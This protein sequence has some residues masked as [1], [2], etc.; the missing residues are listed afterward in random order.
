[1]NHDTPTPKRT[2]KSR[3]LYKSKNAT[4]WPGVTRY[5]GDYAAVIK[6]KGV[7]HS[8]GIYASAEAAHKAYLRTCKSLGIKV[9]VKK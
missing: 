8:L 7:S 4:G 1:M 6:V 2:F 3:I 5:L 9:K